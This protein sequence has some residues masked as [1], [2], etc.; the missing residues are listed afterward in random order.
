MQT[1]HDIDTA[2][3]LAHTLKGTAGNIGA[4]D[5]QQHT[6]AL[7]AACV[8][9]VA[10]EIINTALQQCRQ[11]LQLVM[12]ELIEFFEKQDCYHKNATLS[13]N[14][15]TYSVAQWQAEF[16]KLLVMATDFETVAIDF[17]ENIQHKINDDVISK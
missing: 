1:A 13:A 7:E 4:T 6:A 8:H 14:D 10:N 12:T 17:A 5:L 3:I 11:K 2:T 15:K 16:S 9:N